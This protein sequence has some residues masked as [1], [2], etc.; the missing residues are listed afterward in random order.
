MIKR[1]TTIPLVL[2]YVQVI[3]LSSSSV[4]ERNMFYLTM[5]SVAEMGD[6]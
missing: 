2:S 1:R 4:R 3:K 5:L 6:K